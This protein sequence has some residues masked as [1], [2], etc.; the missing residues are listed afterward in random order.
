MPFLLSILNVF[1]VTTIWET[2]KY[3]LPIMDWDDQ[4]IW[5]KYIRFASKVICIQE[6][7]IFS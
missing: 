3:I 6:L 7:N 2:A 1:N 4:T 5:N